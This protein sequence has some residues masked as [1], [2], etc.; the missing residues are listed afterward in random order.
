M[1]SERI[2]VR[3]AFVFHHLVDVAALW[4]TSKVFE[5]IIYLFIYYCSYSLKE[6]CFTKSYLHVMY[7]IWQIYMPANLNRII[8]SVILKEKQV[9]P[10]AVCFW[11][12]QGQLKIF[13]MLPWWKSGLRRGRKKQ[14]SE[15]SIININNFEGKDK[16]RKST[17]PYL[18]FWICDGYVFDLCIKDGRKL[19]V[20]AR[21]SN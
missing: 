18:L 13:S 7:D 16:I 14:L 2:R 5:S 8:K 3:V 10:Q 1:S 6:K 17:S 21:L 15:W 11:L 9:L 20:L 4:Y 12:E 19:S